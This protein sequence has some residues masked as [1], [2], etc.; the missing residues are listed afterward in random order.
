VAL[1]PVPPAAVVW[2]RSV[3]VGAPWSGR[4]VHGVQL[5]AVGRSFYTWDPVLHRRPDRP[6][7]RWGN[8]RLIRIV[9]RIAAAYARRHPGQ[10]LGIG[11]LSR[12]HGGPFLPKHESHQ[13][14]LDVDVYFPRR[15]RRERPPDSASDID[16]RLAQEVVTRFVRAG[17]IRIFVGPHTH[18]TGPAGVVQI[19][20]NHDNHLHVRI[21]G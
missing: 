14:G 15:D 11:D 19:L 7:R 20:A 1:P 17:A 13:N 18:L 6:G 9:L 8:A 3:S 2:H 16:H 5:P 4:L 12:R 10:R 21:R